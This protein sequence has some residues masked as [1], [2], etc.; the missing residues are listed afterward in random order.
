MED[1]ATNP[2][3]T[4]QSLH[5]FQCARVELLETKVLR[6]FKRKKLAQ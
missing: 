4:L 3:Q 6:V 5:V 1:K 2:S